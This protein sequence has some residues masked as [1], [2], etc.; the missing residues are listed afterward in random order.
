[1]ALRTATKTPYQIFMHIME[2]RG[3]AG[4]D[5]NHM[6]DAYAT[7]FLGPTTRTQRRTEAKYETV[8]AVWQSKFLFEDVMLTDEEFEKEKLAIGVYNRNDFARNQLIGMHEFSLVNIQRQ[9]GSQYDRQWF[10]LTVP[11][12]P[13]QIQGYILVTT[14]VLR[15]GASPPHP[16]EKK[17]EDDQEKMILTDPTLRARSPYLLNVLIYRGQHIL[18]NTHLPALSGRSPFVSVRFNGNVARTPHFTNT[19]SPV[20]NYRLSLPFD[21]PLTSES[22]EL[23]LWNHVTGRPDQLISEVTF[24]YYLESL[25]HKAFGP[26]WVNLYSSEYTSKQVTLLGSI[27]DRLDASGRNNPLQSEYVGRV[28]VR[29]SVTPTDR[30]NQRLLV[31]TCNPVALPLSVEYCLDILLYSSLDIPVLGGQVRVEVSF[32]DRLASSSGNGQRGRE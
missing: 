23:Q 17:G 11:E 2:A 27:K 3:L 13:S 4:L 14:Y 24:N 22:I 20:W 19:T 6:S 12:Q 10:P 21:M 30:N 29:M 18:E 28:L 32:G 8:N 5:E 16:E 15:P 9:K 7:V 1:M 25:T 31:S 26:R